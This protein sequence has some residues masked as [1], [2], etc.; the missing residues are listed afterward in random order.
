[1]PVA[2]TGQ[3]FTDT[4]DGG[5]RMHNARDYSIINGT[6]LYAVADGFVKPIINSVCGTGLQIITDTD[7]N[8]EFYTFGYCHMDE[9]LPDVKNKKVKAGT[10][11]GYSNNTG[12]SGGPH[13]H[14]KIAK[15]NNVTKHKDYINPDTINFLPLPSE[16]TIEEEKEEEIVEQLDRKNYNLYSLSILSLF[17]I[18]LG[19]SENT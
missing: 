9:V 1:M 16:E 8:N 2:S 4:R 15:V 13:L 7:I 14:L 6:P 19:E 5:S 18:I 12:I 10:L 17:I 3:S 11:I